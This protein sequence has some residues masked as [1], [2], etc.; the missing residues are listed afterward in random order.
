MQSNGC[1]EFQL[2]L[3]NDSAGAAVGSRVSRGWLNLGN[4]SVPHFGIKYI[5]EGISGGSGDPVNGV[6][7]EMKIEAKFYLA[8]KEVR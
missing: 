3:I 5:F 6:K 2:I 4:S 8:F 7:V 1:T